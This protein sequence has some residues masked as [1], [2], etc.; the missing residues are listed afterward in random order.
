MLLT[1]I[2]REQLDDKIFYFNQKLSYL[3]H[4]EL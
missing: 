3:Y 1:I 2:N 4:A